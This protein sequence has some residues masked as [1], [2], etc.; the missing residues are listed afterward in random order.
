MTHLSVRDIPGTNV[1]LLEGKR[2]EILHGTLEYNFAYMCKMKKER[3]RYIEGKIL[4][5]KKNNTMNYEL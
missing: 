4:K 1:T 5:D 2:K 3:K